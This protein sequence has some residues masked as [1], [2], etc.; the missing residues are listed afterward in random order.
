MSVEFYK[1]QIE[2]QASLGSLAAKGVSIAAKGLKSFGG[3]SAMKRIGTGAVI[4]SGLGAV[5]GSV[6]N[7]DGS[8]IGGA[9]K[10]AL[11]GALTGGLVG[12]AINN[13]NIAKLGGKAATLGEKASNSAFNGTF[14][15]GIMNNALN[16]AG[17]SMNSYGE[18]VKKYFGGN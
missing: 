2:K 11:S 5:K 10:G 13:T 1:T 9:V 12:N 18:K 16:Q 7:Q 17:V 15:T 3:M 14:G 6:T 4:G 8:K